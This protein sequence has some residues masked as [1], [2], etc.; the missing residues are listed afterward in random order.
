MDYT[1]NS[2]IHLHSHT[3]SEFSPVRAKSPDI[4]QTSTKAI[5]NSSNQQ[6]LEKFD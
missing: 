2:K 5:R 6:S 3:N 4:Y 1:N